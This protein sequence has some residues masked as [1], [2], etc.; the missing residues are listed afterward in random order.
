MLKPHRPS[1]WLALLGASAVDRARPVMMAEDPITSSKLASYSLIEL[2]ALGRAVIQQP[3]PLVEESS[4][5]NNLP[6]MTQPFFIAV[7]VELQH[8]YDYAGWRLCQRV[9]YA[10]T[11][12]VRHLF[13]EHCSLMWV[14]N[15]AVSFSPVL[16]LSP[17]EYDFLEPGV[18][19]AEVW[20]ETG[21]ANSASSNRTGSSGSS[22]Y[23]AWGRV[24]RLFEVGPPPSRDINGAIIYLD[25]TSD[26]FEMSEPSNST[27]LGAIRIRPFAGYPSVVGVIV[28]PRSHHP[29]LAYV[30][31]N[32][33]TQL[34]AVRPIYV[35]HGPNF[36]A[37][38]IAAESKSNAN[39]VGIGNGEAESNAERLCELVRSEQVVLHKLRVENFTFRDY[40]RFVTSKVLWNR[41]GG[42]KVGRKF[43]VCISS[44]NR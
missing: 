26:T 44:L 34:P 4:A 30:I 12:S 25:D 17:P 3:P 43:T 37:C 19:E 14:Q 10:D 15:G 35:F 8:G 29:N 33:A 9:V 36:D 23:R 13:G 38:R 40:N 5:T 39:V 6:F 41:I 27:Q 11:Y 42:D 1:F 16:G 21:D 22:P 7:G 2:E 18:H 28:E 31:I 32:V 20:F 24:T